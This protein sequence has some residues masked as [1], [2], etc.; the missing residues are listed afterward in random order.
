M[1]LKGK[2]RAADLRLRRTYGITLAEYNLQ[3]KK[4]K[5]ICAICGRPP[6]KVRLAVDHNHAVERAKITA[7]PYGDEYSARAVVGDFVHFARGKT[8][9]E[10]VGTLRLHLKRMSVRGL[11]CMICNRKVLGAMERF[12]V[13]PRDVDAYLKTYDPHNQLV[14]DRH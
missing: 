6:K 7:T 9:A 3:L 13:R 14:N 11:L 5:G 10:A 12:K 4:Q 8:K 1:S 2:D